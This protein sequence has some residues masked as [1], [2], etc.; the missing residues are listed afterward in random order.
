MNRSRPDENISDDIRRHQASLGC[1]YNKIM[2]IY[3]RRNL[4]ALTAH[5][6]TKM[7]CSNVAIA[8][9]EITVLYCKNYMK[10][11]C[12]DIKYRRIVINFQSLNL[13]K[14]TPSAKRSDPF[15]I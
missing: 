15:G 14:I 4:R 5:S 3:L 12:I 8:N 9:L 7:H 10:V 11:G 2:Q 6:W 13:Q 1:N